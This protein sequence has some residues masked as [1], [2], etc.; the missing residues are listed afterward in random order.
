MVFLYI[1]IATILL[2]GF[3]DAYSTN[4]ALSLGLKGLNPIMKWFQ[5]KLG[6]NWIVIKM[7]IHIAVASVVFYFYTTAPL[8]AVM[9]TFAISINA[10]VV[11]KNF[12]LVRKASKE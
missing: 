11:Y 4:K 8:V 1:L 9:A 2:V 7:A 5:D 12:K 6:G 10:A 3:L